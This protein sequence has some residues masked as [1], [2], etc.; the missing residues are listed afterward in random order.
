MNGFFGLFVSLG[1]SE[2]RRRPTVSGLFQLYAF[3]QLNMIPSINLSTCQMS[4]L[5]DEEDVVVEDDD[6]D[7]VVYILMPME[8]LVSFLA[9]LF[10][11]VMMKVNMS[12]E[13]LIL[14]IF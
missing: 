12:S 5:R 4:T 14:E 8:L 10:V 9:L 7:G 13:N 3:L 6:D 11:A 2:G 1:L